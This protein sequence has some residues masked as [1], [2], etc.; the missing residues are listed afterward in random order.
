MNY[1]NLNNIHVLDETYMDY[2]KDLTYYYLKEETLLHGLNTCNLEHKHRPF[3]II[4]SKCAH[5]N[6]LCIN[7]KMNKYDMIVHELNKILELHI[8]KKQVYN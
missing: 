8:K 7:Q 3:M 6:Y 2:V 5:K 4:N 1:Y